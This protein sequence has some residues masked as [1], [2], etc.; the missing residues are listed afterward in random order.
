MFFP[1]WTTF[2]TFLLALCLWVAPQSAPADVPVIQSF[3]ADPV[4]I[5]PGEPVTLAWVVTGATSLKLDGVA[6]AGNSTVVNPIVTSEYLLEATNVEGSV[7]ATANVSVVDVPDSASATGRFVE[8]V[9]HAK[10]TRLHLSEIEVFSFGVTPDRAHAD[11]TSG[12]DLVQAGSPSSETPP[13]TTTLEHGN[14]VSVFDG[15]LEN[16]SSV[17]TTGMSLGFEPR[18]MLDLGATHPIGEIRIWGR[19]DTCCADRLQNFSVNVYEDDGL[20]RP[21][22]LVNSVLF[23]DAAP[24]ATVG[25]AEFDLALPD[26]GLRS[27][28]VD[29]PLVPAGEPIVLSWDVNENATA[30]LIDRGVGNVIAL[31]NAFGL[32]SVT[33]DPGPELDTTY[34][35]LVT[36]PSGI[37]VASVRVEVTDQPVIYSFAAD[38]FQV[39]P[40]S[41]VQLAWAVGNVTSLELNGANVMGTSGLTV[42]P[43]GSADYVLTARNAQGVRSETL[44]VRVLSPGEPIISEFMADNRGDVTLDEDSDSS[45]W[46][47]ICNPGALAAPLDGYYLTDDPQNPTKWR[48][49]QVVMPPGSYLVVF[50]SGKN[51]RDPNA[52]LHTN[53]ALDDRGEYLALVKPDGVSV[54]MDFHPTFPAQRAEV[55]YG[56]EEESVKEGYFLEPTPGS[57]NGANFTGFVGDTMFSLDRGFYDAPIEVAVTTSE[58]GAQIRFTVDGTEPTAVRGR[59]YDGPIRIA[60]TTVLRAAGFKPGFVP[61]NVDT[62]TYLFTADI[63]R[64]PSMS[65]SITRHPTYGPR[66]DSSLKAIPSLS[67]VFQGD[68]SRTEKECSVEFIGFEAGSTQFDVGMSRYGNYVTNFAKRSMR[69]NFRSLYGPSKLRFPVFDGYDYKTAPAEEI[70]ALDLRS[71]NHDMVSR[72]AYLS[73]R[74][75]DDSMDAMGNIAP[76]GRFVHIYINGVYWGQYHMRERWSA[77]MLAEYFPGR[78]E[79]Y[80][81]INA[82]NTG[83]NFLDGIPY[84]GTGQFWNQTKSLVRGSLP[85]RRSA[86]HLDIA[87]VVDFML[88]W[89]SGN[90]ESEFRSAGAVRVGVT[91]KFF[92]KD[93]DGFL[94]PPGHSVTHQGPIAAMARLRAEAHPDFRILLADRIHKHFFND[95]AMTVTKTISR[96]RG[97]MIET[98]TS[99]YAESARWNYRTPSSWQSYQ[100]NLLGS[101]LRTLTQT[102]INRFRGAGMYPSL[103]APSFNQHGGIIA[104]GFDLVM[105]APTGTIYYTT[106]GTD[107][108]VSGGAISATALIY[109]G[110]LRLEETSLVKAR[111]RNGSVWSALNEATFAIDSTGLVVSE[112]MYDPLSPSEAEIAAGHTNG[113]DFEFFE[114]LN[115]GTSAIDLNGIVLDEG[116]TF[117]FSTGSITS[118]APGGRL[119]VVEDPVAFE[120]RYG[121]GHPVTGQYSGKLQ[122]AGE[123]V[124]ISNALDATLLEFTYDNNLPWPIAAAGDGSSLVLIDPSSGP[125]HND[126]ASWTASATRGGSPG[127]ESVV[128]FT[129]ANWAA[130]HGVTNP[131]DDEDGDRLT[132]YE[133]FVRGSSP[134]LFS[135]TPGSST[136]VEFLE[137]GGVIDSYLTITFSYSLAAQGVTTTV[138]GSEGLQGWTIGPGSAVH[139]QTVYHGDGSATETWRSA[140]PTSEADEHYLRVVWES[141]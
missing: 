6:I 109:T 120:F 140:T 25:P 40:G 32:G 38:R 81:A 50:A 79:D 12:N 137:V 65:T 91:F 115:T 39:E 17:W 133:E 106:D 135:P 54:V 28:A 114:L 67:L 56:F 48:F 93:A 141:P 47:E 113:E 125:D 26:P 68:I 69:L 100:N 7:T 138:E 45:D 97:R 77:A 111:V 123:M 14:A 87:N 57:E 46:I 130:A 107:P 51:R 82:N 62:Q 27:F 129:Y 131:G 127:L 31:T 119:L 136:Q 117:D 16:G 15:N 75:T 43:N 9:K 41:P 72:G 1:R 132:N 103:V 53:F 61:T 10:D 59:V 64:Q 44:R 104:A 49:P 30:V 36:R 134:L 105:N 22:A 98:R 71:G 33:V 92:M 29:K 116:I 2:P 20:G 3:T 99:F 94:R 95:G 42:R 112:F 126:P 73:N 74:F 85:Y 58:P 23:P 96:L 37:S 19:N 76:H 84:D 88:L 118:L 70:D 124:R 80:E 55:S 5:S 8:V 63:I 18:Y 24:N 101:H 78:E 66:M 11:G 4:S 102:M 108:R 83:S 60:R 139:V 21:G 110:A 128:S 13:T 90:S 122:D 121:T 52:E 35:I 86:R 34:S 89:V